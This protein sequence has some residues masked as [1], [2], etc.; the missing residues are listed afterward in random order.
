MRPLTRLAFIVL[1]AA[2]TMCPSVLAA[3]ARPALP[4]DP[5]EL[6]AGRETPGDPSLTIDRDGY[7]YTFATTDN[8]RAFEADPAK[9]E[10]QFGGACARMGPLSGSCSTDHFATHD[11]RIYVFASAACRKTFLKD[12]SRLLEGPDPIPGSTPQALKRGA[13]L[14][15]LAVEGLGGEAALRAVRDVTYRSARTEVSGGKEY[16]VVNAFVARLPDRFALGE[17]WNTDW[18]GH[19]AGPD[20]AAA[21]DSKG[22]RTPLV[23]SQRESLGRE[24]YRRTLLL[25][26]NHA[27]PGFVA[28]ALPPASD[29]AAPTSER[30]AVSF[31][32]ATTTL[33]VDLET[34]R[35]LRA[36]RPARGPD[37]FLTVATHVFDDF[38]PVGGLT[39]PHKVTTAYAS[40]TAGEPTTQTLE[41]SINTASGDDLGA[42]LG[43]ALA[44]DANR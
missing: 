20:R 6:I 17:A 4:V 29:D 25:L 27:T 21:I 18:W 32:G 13:E 14:I 42:R 3:P 11:G 2:P 41:I 12:P 8:T 37:S 7:T 26:A 10:I 33:T 30:V 19:E 22:S 24:A 31:R 1:A 43:A 5:V 16:T 44:V 9:Y 40:A 28:A 38:R 35:V 36:E 15:T 34:G 23:A 39:L